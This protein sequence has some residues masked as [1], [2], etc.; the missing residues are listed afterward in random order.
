MLW[1]GELVLR[2]GVAVGQL[3]S[4]AWG[5]TVGGAVGLGYLRHPA[6]E[7]VT[8]E[9]LD[10][11]RYEINAGGDRYPAT[12]SLRPPFDPAGTRVRDA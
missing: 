9:F 8:R 5:E 6:G 3:T 7:V 11:G 1:G 4:A 2:D 10:A 12:V